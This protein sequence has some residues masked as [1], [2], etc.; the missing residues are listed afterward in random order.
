MR[1]NSTT[2]TKSPPIPKATCTPARWIRGGGC[3][4]SS[5]KSAEG[6][7]SKVPR[8]KAP[9]SE[10]LARYLAAAILNN[11]KFG[12]NYDRA[13]LRSGRALQILHNHPHVVARIV[14]DLPLIVD[15][16]GRALICVVGRPFRRERG[17]RTAGAR[18][19]RPHAAH[20]FG[21]RL[22]IGTVAHFVRLLLR[23]IEN[24]GKLDRVRRMPPASLHRSLPG[25]EVHICRRLAL[26]ELAFRLPDGV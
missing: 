18:K 5:C 3:R 23:I 14:H 8:A 26:C 2:C 9:R 22:Q 24:E 17:I 7:E 21:Q 19:G 20:L 25:K 12:T 4:N 10:G 6:L 1:V 16:H 11:R 13:E 15:N